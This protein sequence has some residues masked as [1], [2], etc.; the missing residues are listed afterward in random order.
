[1]RVW[2]LE[3]LPG[4]KVIAYSLGRDADS[5]FDLTPTTLTQSEVISGYCNRGGVGQL[6]GYYWEIER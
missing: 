5:F 1:M 6:K 2:W 4:D 3:L